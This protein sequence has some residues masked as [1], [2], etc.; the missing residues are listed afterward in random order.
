ME[1]TPAHRAGDARS[2]PGRPRPRHVVLAGGGTAGHVHLGIAVA[3]AYRLRHPGT[4]ITLL[5]TREGPEA[6]LAPRA[7]LGFLALPAAPW[8]GSGTVGRLRAPLAVARSHARARAWLRQQPVDLVVGLGSHASLGPVLA[9][10]R[11]GLATA[12]LE[13]NARAGVANRVLGRVSRVALLG[14][15]SAAVDFPRTRVAVTGVPL[16]RAILALSDRQA[17]AAPHVLVSGGSSRWGFLDERLPEL[18]GEVAR[19]V[20]GLEVR[21]HSGRL[22]PSR[23]RA[24][25]ASRGIRATVTPF[26]ADM[27]ADYGWARLAVVCSGAVTLAEVA[28]AGLPAAVIPFSGAALDHQEANAQEFCRATGAP[29]AREESWR[30][31]PLAEQLATLLRSEEA[32]QDLSAKVRAVGRPQ[33]AAEVVEACEALLRSGTSSPGRTQPAPGGR[34]ATSASAPRRVQTVASASPTR[35]GPPAATARSAE[36]S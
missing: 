24:A 27:A 5:G 31:R 1:E 15:E 11:L 30:P 18:L 7:G 21:H 9:A 2:E 14:S 3:E 26:A 4:R 16:R 12:V 17:V 32:W 23:V 8:F 29:H 22:D 33:A 36:P 20:P 19:R 6:R 13:P 28:L 35:G 25:Y 10:W 34:A